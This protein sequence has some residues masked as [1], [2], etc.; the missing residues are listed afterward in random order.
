M[1]LLRNFWN[2]FDS[3]ALLQLV[4]QI[5]AVV[6]C[7][8]IHELSHGIAAYALGDQTAKR[9]GRLSL[10]PF[11]H[12]DL[13][14]FLMLLV[15]HVG[16]AK[17]VP[18]D[19]RRFK[20][21][22]VGMALTAVAGPLSNFLTALAALAGGTLLLHLFPQQESAVLAYTLFF[23]CCTAVLSVGLGLFN[24]IPVPPLDGSRV[25]FA[26]LPDR[27]YYFVMRYERWLML[28]IIALA[29]FDLLSGPIDV[30]MGWMLK[31]MCAVTEFPFFYLSWYFGF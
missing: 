28:I 18:V 3:A 22:K 25:L 12:V 21:P 7:L 4:I 16:W 9:A 8:T 17:P 2:N 23:L 5:A 29:W 19:M 30:C 24:L 26:F 1:D 15:A 13:V 31:G 6:L 11:R 10:N 27:L 20:H 14:G